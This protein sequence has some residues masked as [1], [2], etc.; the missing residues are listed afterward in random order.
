MSRAF[1]AARLKS[2]TVY[3][4]GHYRPAG[5]IPIERTGAEWQDSLAR[6]RWE[7]NG[8]CVA[9]YDGAQLQAEIYFN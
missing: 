6:L 7:F 1:N 5:F 8:D 9:V 4:G 3:P 2:R